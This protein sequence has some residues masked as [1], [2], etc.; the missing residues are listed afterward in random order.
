METRGNTLLRT[1]TASRF[2]RTISKRDVRRRKGSGK[3]V[4]CRRVIATLRTPDAVS[5][6]QCPT[7]NGLI[8]PSSRSK[9]VIVRAH[10]YA[11]SFRGF[12]LDT[13]SAPARLG[14]DVAT[15]QYLAANCN[16]SVKIGLTCSLLTNKPRRTCDSII[17]Q[18]S[19]M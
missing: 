12:R 6:R 8:P 5:P 15:W 14:S 16:V 4:R 3:S 17:F 13:A 19:I 9:E 18:L 2:P 1:P 7:K 10:S 11:P